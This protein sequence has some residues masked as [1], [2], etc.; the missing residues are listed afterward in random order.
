MHHTHKCISD[1][2]VRE[3]PRLALSSK[4]GDIQLAE[5]GASSE[6]D[7]NARSAQAPLHVSMGALNMRRVF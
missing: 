2:A 7:T 1:P 6:S 3:L 4:H 5:D